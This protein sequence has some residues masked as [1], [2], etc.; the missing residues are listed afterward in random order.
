M[1]PGNPFIFGSKGQRSKSRGTKTLPTW[2]TALLCVL[3]SST[4]IRHLSKTGNFPPRRGSDTHVPSGYATDYAFLND[5]Q[6]GRRT[7]PGRSDQPSTTCSTS[8]P[9]QHL[10][11]SSLL[12]RRPHSLELSPGFYPGLHHQCRLFQTFAK[13]VFVRS[14]LVHSAR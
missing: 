12:S 8:L 2:V 4:L 3:A 5:F 7:F 13:N 1:S 11:L 10:W 6:L 14:I 9:A